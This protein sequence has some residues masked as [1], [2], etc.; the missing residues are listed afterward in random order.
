MLI[1]FNLTSKSCGWWVPILVALKEIK[2]KNSLN[3]LKANEIAACNDRVKN[4]FKACGNG[5]DGKVLR[6][7]AKRYKFQLDFY[8]TNKIKLCS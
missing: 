3:Q 2:I 7:N 1:L 8:P 5:S 6:C 4:L